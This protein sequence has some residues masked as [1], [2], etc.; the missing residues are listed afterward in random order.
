[1]K[2]LITVDIRCGELTC[3]ESK[4]K[5]CKYFGTR[6]MGTEWVCRLFPTEEDSFTPLEEKNGWTLRCNECLKQDL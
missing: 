3:A 4:G 2:K 5:F 1:M 6:R